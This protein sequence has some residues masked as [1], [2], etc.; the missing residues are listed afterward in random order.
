MKK[1][2][3][4]RKALELLMEGNERFVMDLPDRPYPNRMRRKELLEGQHP[5]AALLCCADSRVAP[6]LFFDQG[7]G[8][9]FV[10]RVAGNIFDDEAILG[11]LEYALAMLEVP[12]FLVMGHQKCGAVQAALEGSE[13]NL[14]IDELVRAIRPVIETVEGQEGDP[15]NNAV[16]ANALRVSRQLRNADPIFKEAVRSDRV[17]VLAAYQ[18]LETGRVELLE[19]L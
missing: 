4:P 9:L 2:N 3:T 8:D 6:E 16:R 19:S 13:T 10:V 5:F 7:L 12:L 14:A 1:A 11:S 17:A 18:C 15:L